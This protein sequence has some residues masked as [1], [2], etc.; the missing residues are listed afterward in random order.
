MNSAG[1]MMAV[2]RKTFGLKTDAGAIFEISGEVA[3]IVHE[4]GM[5][6]GIACVFVPGSTG[7][8]T[9]IEY[10]DGVLHDLDGALDRLVPKD[11]DYKHNSRWGDGNGYAHVRASLLGPSLTVPFTNGKLELGKWQQIVFLELDNRGRSREIIVQVIG[12]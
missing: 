3:D 4:S 1:G 12:E 9:T 8:V 11:I 7:A 10:E 2:F 6:N 5:K